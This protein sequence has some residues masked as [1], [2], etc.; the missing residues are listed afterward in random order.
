MDFGFRQDQHKQQSLQNSTQR[1]DLQEQQMEQANT[2]TA[3]DVE[4]E[5]INYDSQI[6]T[7]GLIQG[8]YLGMGFDEGYRKAA[9]NTMVIGKHLGELAKSLKMEEKWEF[10]CIGK[11]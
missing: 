7:L 8:N 6:C 4:E 3:M 11:L 5:L 9:S 10:H 1:Q 2:S